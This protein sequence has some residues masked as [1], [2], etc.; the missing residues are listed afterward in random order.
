MLSL[1][2]VVCTYPHS[3]SPSSSL[4][5]LSLFLPSSFPLSLPPSL[6][7]YL[8]VTYEGGQGLT[9][10]FLSTFHRMFPDRTYHCPGAYHEGQTNCPTSSE[11][12][13]CSTASAPGLQ[14]HAQGPDSYM[15]VGEQNSHSSTTNPLPNEL[16]S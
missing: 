5:Y 4:S 13:P 10:C 7:F 12:P 8:F 11:D 16:I 1:S 15:G 9:S 2:S 3:L 6:L 14:G